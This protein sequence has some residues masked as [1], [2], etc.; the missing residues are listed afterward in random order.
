MGLR[1]EDPEAHFNKLLSA[2]LL[3][4]AEQPFIEAL[5]DLVNGG[6]VELPELRRRLVVFESRS[7]LCVSAHVESQRSVER[8]TEIEF[9]HLDG[10]EDIADK[11]NDPWPAAAV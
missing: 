4:Q 3:D 7:T 5:G 2:H 9:R 10:R 8:S 1:R 11:I 6:V